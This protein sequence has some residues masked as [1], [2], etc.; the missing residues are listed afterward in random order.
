MIVR[1]ALGLFLV[2]TLIVPAGAAAA[3]AEVTPTV[4]R[5]VMFE[6]DAPEAA[7]ALLHA[8]A[9]ATVTGTLPEID[10]VRV[11]MPVTSAVVYKNSPLVAGMRNNRPFHLMGALPNDPL[12]NLQWGLQQIGALQAWGFETG[13]KN[14]VAVAVIDTGVDALH[15][16]LKGRV[17]GGFDFLEYDE[18]T[19]DDHGHGTH[20]SGIIAANVSN[21]EG[22]AGINHGAEII[23]M[24]AC[25]DAGA[26][27]PYETIASVIDSV[28]RGA[29]VINM[30]LGGPGPCD[31]IGQTL[32]Q[33]VRDQG[34]L[35]VVAAGNSAKPK[36]PT[37]SPANCDNTL[38][39][40]AIN[41]KGKRASF[42][43]YGDFVDIAA[44]G[45]EVW[46]TVPPLVS[47]TSEHIGYDA[48]PGTSMAAPHV[49]AAASLIKAAHPDWTPDQI[50][51]KLIRSAT[52]VG[53]PGR[54]D[55]YGHGLL[56]LFA[57]LR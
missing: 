4:T 25:T 35:T 19:Y 53:K 2:A 8:S 17:S 57:A 36:N 7:R 45:V 38:A 1:R 50:E 23:P 51:Q 10:V 11:E 22:I 42:S 56:N 49:A 48:Y 15:A 54:D 16:D 31:D 21:N 14:P 41:P 39:V 44:P 12:L 52:D 26:C 24:K 40:G 9:G 29:D 33:W 55:F 6:R 5:L 3:P 32:Y 47:L 46:S 18:D 28:R 27:P 13:K 43:S 34:V 20:V 37:I 30:S